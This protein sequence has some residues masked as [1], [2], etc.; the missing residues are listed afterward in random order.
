[1]DC[2]V[3]NCSGN[4]SLPSIVSAAA[5][6]EDRADL[7]SAPAAL[8]VAGGLLEGLTGLVLLLLYCR[9][10][11][12]EVRASSLA[13]GYTITLACASAIGVSFLWAEDDITVTGYFDGDDLLSTCSLTQ[14]AKKASGVA[15]E[16]CGSCTF[17]V[18]LT[19]FALTSLWGTVRQWSRS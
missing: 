4:S 16:G 5:E 14:L 2:P 18:W 13:L 15:R 3:C 6:S 12:P 10:N 1:M 17:R 19:V 8:T 11:E 9:R 7:G